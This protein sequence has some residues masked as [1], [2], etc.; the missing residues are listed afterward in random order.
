MG[1]AGAG[2]TLP[3]LGLW[4]RKKFFATQ[5]FIMEMYDREELDILKHRR[6]K[7][8]VTEEDYEAL[9]GIEQDD[10]KLEDVLHPREYSESDA[11]DLMDRLEIDMKTAIILSI[12]KR[13]PVFVTEDTEYRRLAKSLDIDVYNRVEFLKK[14]E[15]MQDDDQ[16]KPEN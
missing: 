11:R 3:L 5:D 13:I 4:R 2:L 7:W 14:F 6:R 9:K 12:A 1:L 16:A 10:V 15:K 8:F